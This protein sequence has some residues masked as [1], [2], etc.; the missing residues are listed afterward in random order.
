MKLLILEFQHPD[1][2]LPSEI[3]FHSLPLEPQTLFQRYRLLIFRELEYQ[4]L[5]QKEKEKLSPLSIVLEQEEKYSAWIRELEAMSSSEDQLK[6]IA[7][8]R[9]SQVHLQTFTESNFRSMSTQVTAIS[10]RLTFVLKRF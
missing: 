4:L 9:W 7:M 8:L 1:K 3:D 6:T 2:P 10:T 5:S